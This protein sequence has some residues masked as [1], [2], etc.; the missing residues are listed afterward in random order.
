MFGLGAI[1]AVILTGQ[2]AVRRRDGR[3]GAGAGGAGAS[4]DDCFARLDACGAEPEL[5]ALCKRCLAPEPADRPADAGEVAKAVAALRAAA[6]ERA[7]QAELDGYGRGRA[8]TAE[9]RRRSGGS[10]G[11]CGSGR[12]RSW[13]WRWSAG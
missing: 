8:A 9:A 13:P 4:C 11:G 1:L 2:A 10:G 12:R 6:D 5:V 7:R 3:V